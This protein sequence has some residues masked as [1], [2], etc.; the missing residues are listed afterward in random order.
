MN[1]WVGVKIR[2]FRVGVAGARVAKR[3]CGGVWVWVEVCVC[4]GWMGGMWV[5]GGG[6]DVWG[7]R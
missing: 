4:V 2:A 1:E 7:C 3:V 5:C 6:V